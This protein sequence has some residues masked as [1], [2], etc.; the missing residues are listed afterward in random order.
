[1]KNITVIETIIIIINLFDFLHILFE[2]LN[3]LLQ[4][5]SII[6]SL[7]LHSPLTHVDPKS[8]GI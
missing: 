4:S 6:H 1:M 2:H 5:V 3:P 8:H 7:N